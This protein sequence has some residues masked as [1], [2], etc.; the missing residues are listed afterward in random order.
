MTTE[1]FAI[2]F[3]LG[4]IKKEIRDG[5]MR[6][7]AGDGR[8]W[9][10]SPL[11]MRAVKATE[12]L[13]NNGRFDEAI[14]KHLLSLFP[15]NGSILSEAESFVREAVN[16]ALRS[17]IKKHVGRIVAGMVA[18]GEVNAAIEAEVRRR[19]AELQRGDVPPG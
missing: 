18:S 3:D 15:T 7:L 12:T 2:Q 8:G 19:V 4:E 5:V 16:S 13:L 1:M 14:E 17:A 10:P 9:A 6:V 11:S